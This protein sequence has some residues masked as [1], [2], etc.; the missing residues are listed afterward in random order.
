MHEPPVVVIG[1]GR[2]GTEAAYQLARRG[3]QVHL[4]EMRPQTP[5]PVLGFRW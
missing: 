4:Y 2:A 5:T 1:G 3:L